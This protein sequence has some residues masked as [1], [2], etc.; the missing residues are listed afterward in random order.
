MDNIRTKDRDDADISIAARDIAG[1]LRAHNTVAEPAGNYT[2]PCDKRAG[3][4]EI[5]GS[6]P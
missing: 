5:Y 4:A 2:S 1:G 6:A 3:G